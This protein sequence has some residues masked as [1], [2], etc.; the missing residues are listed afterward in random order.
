MSTTFEVSKFFTLP[1]I[2]AG[3]TLLVACA[4]AWQGSTSAGGDNAG[5]VDAAVE[6]IG[7]VTPMTPMC[8]VV[9]K[10]LVSMAAASRVSALRPT[11]SHWRHEEEDAAAAWEAARCPTPALTALVFAASEIAED[12]RRDRIAGGSY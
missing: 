1:V 2:L 12:D 7:Q 6:A 4:S 9:G 5:Q 8:K 10:R 3:A 11:G